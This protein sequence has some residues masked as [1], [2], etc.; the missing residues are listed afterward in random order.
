[1]KYY[2]INSG[3]SFTANTWSDIKKTD[4]YDRATFEDGDYD[5]SA[6]PAKDYFCVVDCGWEIWVVGETKQQ[7][8]ERIAEYEA[9]MSERQVGAQ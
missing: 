5:S 8:R 3:D 9:W 6:H 7:V 2:S 1:M 4:L